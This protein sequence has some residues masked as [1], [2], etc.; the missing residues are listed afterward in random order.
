ME[1]MEVG[2]NEERGRE[3]RSACAMNAEAC[4]SCE[5]AFA[6]CLQSPADNDSFC[7]LCCSSFQ[8]G[9]KKTKCMLKILIIQKLSSTSNIIAE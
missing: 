5:D 4:V 3:I 6:A 7:F 1:R 8:N 9:S 2:S